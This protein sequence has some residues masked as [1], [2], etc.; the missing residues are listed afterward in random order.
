[1]VLSFNVS[2][3][4]VSESSVLMRWSSSAWARS[5]CSRRASLRFSAT[6]SRPRRCSASSSASTSLS[7]HSNRQ[8]TFP[9][10]HSSHL[11]CVPTVHEQWASSN[12]DVKYF[13]NWGLIIVIVIIAIIVFF[14]FV[15]FFFLL[16]SE[17]IRLSFTSNHIWLIILVY[18]HQYIHITFILMLLPRACTK[19]H[20]SLWVKITAY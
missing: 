2:T 3:L 9:E 17:L 18:K 12:C 8:W 7:C 11:L 1:M 10:S 20:F 13:Y 14:V 5:S 15:L 16:T 6:T 4:T 19:A